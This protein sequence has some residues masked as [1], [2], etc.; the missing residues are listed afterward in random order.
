M[1]V[2]VV[3]INNKKIED[4]ELSDSIFGIEP[5]NEVLL[6]YIRVFTTNKRQG[7]ANTKTRA[8][9]SGGGVKPRPQKGSGRSRQGSI[10]S[11]IW[12]HGGRAH[13]PKSKD[14]NLDLPK[15]MVALA[16]KSA[17]SAKAKSNKLVVLSGLEVKDGKTKE[18]AK[19]MQN[20][21]LNNS[22]LMVWSTSDEMVKRASANLPMLTTAFAGNLN[23]HDVI[24]NDTLV[25]LKDSVKVLEDKYAS[26]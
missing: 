26:R 17:L 22:S 5:N 1:K 13:G 25:L 3:D 2:A 6:Q 4:I 20:L 8:E 12:V 23:A 15:K 7:N 14:W 19:V 10:R 21:G 16:I 24:S 18:L 9:V 11:P